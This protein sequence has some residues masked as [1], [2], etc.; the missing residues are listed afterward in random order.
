MIQFINLVVRKHPLILFI[1]FFQCLNQLLPMDYRNFIFRCSI[2]CNFCMLWEYNNRTHRNLSSPDSLLYS[3][4]KKSALIHWILEQVLMLFVRLSLLPFF[5]VI[6]LV[7]SMFLQNNLSALI[8]HIQNVDSRWDEY[9]DICLWSL[10]I[11]ALCN[12]IENLMLSKST[13]YKGLH[14]V[15]I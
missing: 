10:V 8:L 3:L 15:G 6:L 14:R 12:L 9:Q 5:R 2:P 1:F 13:V 11:L 4:C 7:I